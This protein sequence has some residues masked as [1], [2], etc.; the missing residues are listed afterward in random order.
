M[1]VAMDIE[2]KFS[3]IESYNLGYWHKTYEA[4]N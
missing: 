1:A 4:F 3:L 2:K